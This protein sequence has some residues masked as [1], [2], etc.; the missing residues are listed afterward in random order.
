[1]DKLLYYVKC[2]K[3]KWYDHWYEF[4]VNRQNIYK[5]YK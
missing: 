3:Y 1:M 2:I 4:S 5:S